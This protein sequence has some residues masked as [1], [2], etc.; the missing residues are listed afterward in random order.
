MARVRILFAA[1]LA[2]SALAVLT[3]PASASVPAASSSKFC[4]DVKGLT[5][6]F[7]DASAKAGSSPTKAFSSIAAQLKK[8]AKDAPAKVKAATNKIASIYSA[9]ASGD[10]SS[11]SKLSDSNFTKSITTF[12]TYVGQSCAGS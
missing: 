8:A 9:I 6:K 7:N 1:L 10:V 11:L 2:V 12:S 4:S 5:A 3:V